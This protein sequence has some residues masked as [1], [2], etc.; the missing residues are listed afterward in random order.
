MTTDVLFE[1]SSLGK[2]REAR[3]SF[4]VFAI[5][6]VASAQVIDILI[7]KHNIYEMC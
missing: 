3:E 2:L 7:P 1:D 6:Q 4:S 5:F